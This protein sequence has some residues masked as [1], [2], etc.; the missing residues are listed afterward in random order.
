MDILQA[1]NPDVVEVPADA[2]RYNSLRTFDFA[3]RVGARCMLLCVVYPSRG[4][5]R[6]SV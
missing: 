2:A 4:C 1:W 3:V 5:E 6:V